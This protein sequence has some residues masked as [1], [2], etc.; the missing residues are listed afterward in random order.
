M[1]LKWLKINNKNIANFINQLNTT[2]LYIY[3]CW[4]YSIWKEILIGK[5][6]ATNKIQLWIYIGYF[7]GY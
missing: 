7:V 4:I 2:N 3:G 1:L 5:D 6:A